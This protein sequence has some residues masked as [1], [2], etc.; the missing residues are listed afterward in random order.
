MGELCEDMFNC[1]V[2]DELRGMINSAEYLCFW[3]QSLFGASHLWFPERLLAM[4][5]ESVF[6]ISPEV[7]WLHLVAAI[8]VTDKLRKV[9]QRTRG[10]FHTYPLY[11]LLYCYSRRGLTS[12]VNGSHRPCCLCLIAHSQFDTATS[13]PPRASDA[14]STRVHG[15]VQWA[16]RNP[17]SWHKPTITTGLA[18]PQNHTWQCQECCQPRRNLLVNEHGV[19]LRPCTTVS[20]FLIGQCEMCMGLVTDSSSVFVACFL[21]L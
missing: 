15:L 8:A 2:E 11:L 19:I 16:L 9:T 12:I 17:V 5:L 14:I 21:W 18:E 13:T 6:L 4:C 7:F 10:A 1:G 20:L 3:V